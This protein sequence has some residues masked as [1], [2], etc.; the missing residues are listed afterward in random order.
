MSKLDPG[1]ASSSSAPGRFIALTLLS[2]VLPGSVACAQADPLL[3]WNEVGSMKYDWK[4]VLPVTQSE[5]T[6]IDILLEPD[7]TMLRRASATNARLLKAYPQ[8]YALDATH[9]PHITLLQLFVRT[10]D[11][12]QLYAVLGR[13]FARVPPMKLEA[14]KYY[15]IPT[16]E[17]GVSGIVARPIPELLGLQADIIAAAGPFM[18][19]TGTISA[20]TAR[21]DNA[22]TD[23]EM[24]AYVS[25]FVQ[26]ATGAHYNPHVTTGVAPRAYLDTMLAEPFPSFTFSPSGA[27]VY[28][29][30]PYGTAARQLKTWTFK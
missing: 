24:V 10:A 6:A 2:L 12:D 29:L 28:Q 13:V 22:S 3:S 11:L 25:S 17:L 23:A 4:E 20:F 14:F 9:T 1:T 27:A 8:G 26:K 19:S 15:Y 21:H 7:A 5:V 18:L 30:G 16:G